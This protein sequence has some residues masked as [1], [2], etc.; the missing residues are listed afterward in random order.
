[1]SAML[2]QTEIHHLDQHLVKALGIYHFVESIVIQRFGL[3]L[4]PFDWTND[5]HDLGHDV[6]M[7]SF[8]NS[9]KFYELGR[10]NSAHSLFMM[11]HETFSWISMNYYELDKAN[12]V[13]G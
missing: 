5:V 4:G 10:I 8:M 7:E 1:M 11:V 6:H 3:K 9:N 12:S 13:H 2:V